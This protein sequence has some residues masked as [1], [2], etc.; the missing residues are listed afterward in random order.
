MV[1][2]F[3]PWNPSRFLPFPL[4]RGATANPRAKGTP[5]LF[6][7][8]YATPAFSLF[9]GERKHGDRVPCLGLGHCFFF[10]PHSLPRRIFS[11]FF[12]FPRKQGISKD[13]LE[14]GRSFAPR[15]RG[16]FFS[17]PF[18]LTQQSEHALTLGAETLPSLPLSWG[19]GRFFS[20]GAEMKPPFS[21]SPVESRDGTFSPSRETLQPLHRGLSFPP[22]L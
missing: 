15:Q 3:S 2:F 19:V 11:F 14:L 4:G 7:P 6:F 9:M 13:W 20:A 1:F 21:F 22:F 12:P 10:L 16:F 8:L 17:S 18:W 5:P